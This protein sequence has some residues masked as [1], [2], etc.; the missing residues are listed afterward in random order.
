VPVSVV[1]NELDWQAFSAAKRV[2]IVD[3]PASEK[4][5]LALEAWEDEGG[6][7]L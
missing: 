4:T 1:S 3:E 7:A 6:P 2:Q 5:S